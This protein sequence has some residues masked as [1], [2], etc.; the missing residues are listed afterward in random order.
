MYS[1]WDRWPRM[2]YLKQIIQFF[3]RL[4]STFLNFFRVPHKWYNW[5][6][7]YNKYDIRDY[8][9]KF[10]YPKALKH[11]IA[12]HKVPN[13]L[14][15]PL[16][17]YGIESPEGWTKLLHRYLKV[18]NDN[19]CPVAQIKEKFGRLTIYYRTKDN[20]QYETLS[21]LLHPIVV[22]STKTCVRCGK[23]GKLKTHGWIVPLCPKHMEPKEIEN[24]E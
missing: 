9:F 5:A 14:K 6:W 3:K 24:E 2:K 1:T 16:W 20:D 18:L 13:E 15:N 17:A 21:K 22:E 19:D 10:K 8:Y 23:P 11:I 4:V 7:P 12:F